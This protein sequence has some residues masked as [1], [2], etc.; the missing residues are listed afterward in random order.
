MKIILENERIEDEIPDF[1]Q[2]NFT[3]SPPM[4]ELSG[5]FCEEDIPY[6]EEE[7]TAHLKESMAFAEQNPNYTLKCST[8]HAF[9]NLKIIIHEGQ[10][11]MVS[12]R[13]N[14]CNPFCHSSSQASQCDRMLYSA[15]N[16][17]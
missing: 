17:R 1:V 13:K 4:L 5:I 7:Y 9:H 3:K 14:A 6:N 12:K 2:E 11:V 16:G 10:W 8:A 15:D